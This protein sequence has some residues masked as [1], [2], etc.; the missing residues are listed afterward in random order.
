MRPLNIDPRT[1]V[2][3]DIKDCKV[4][5]TAKGEILLLTDKQW[6]ISLGQ[7]VVLNHFARLGDIA[8]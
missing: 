6:N 1:V 7:Q 5:L 2:E 4:I 3:K 8:C